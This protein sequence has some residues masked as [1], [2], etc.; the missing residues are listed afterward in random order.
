MS[1]SI[2]IQKNVQNHSVTT[3]QDGISKIIVDC[4]TNED[5][6]RI[7]Y[8]AGNDSGRTLTIKNA[9]GT[10]EMADRLLQRVRG[11]Q[12]QPFEA[13]GALLN[14]QAEMGDGVTVNGVYSGIYVRATTFGRLIE[15]D[16]SAPANE[17]IE[18][19]YTYENITNREYTRFKGEVKA[20]MSL[21]ADRIEAKVSKQS[22]ESQTTFGWELTDTQWRLFN[23][24]GT[25]LSATSAG[26]E[27]KGR[28][29][30]DEGHI[31]GTSGFTIQASKLFSGGKDSLDS[32]DYGVYI[33]TDGIAL[34]SNFK[35]S[36]SGRVDCS[37]LY[38]NG[39]Q[40]TK[41]GHQINSG[42]T[43]GENYASR[44]SG[45]GS[46]GSV[47]TLQ[48]SGSGYLKVGYLTVA[49]AS[50]IK[51]KNRN[52][53]WRKLTVMNASGTN[54]TIYWLGQGGEVWS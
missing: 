31:G 6:E 49:T 18:H 20:S 7:Q 44:W 9:F 48:A 13:S 32:D 52:A 36:S 24:S 51:L 10:Q 53:S 2:N 15:S 47:M 12:Y 38:V 54:S 4:G 17:E 25:I 46:S 5:G 28:I 30:A 19:E 43:G 37:S 14:P 40:V 26:L 50:Y 11:F 35:V 22:P 34:G 33:G 27:V 16:I 29:E 8:E 1:D 41:T 23:E 45:T 42:V 21:F 39:S 3:V